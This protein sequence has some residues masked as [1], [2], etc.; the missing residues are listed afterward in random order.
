MNNATEQ[1]SSINVSMQGHVAIVEIRRPPNNYFDSALI[2]QIAAAFEA[3]E[4]AAAC[5]AIVLCSEGKVFCAGADLA[6]PDGIPVERS[7]REI[8]PIYQQALRLFACTKPVVCA[9]QGAAVGGGVGL[10]LV[11]DFRV[12]CSEARF[13]VNFNRLGFHPGFG[14]S[15]TLPRLIGLQAAAMLFYTGRR[16]GGEEALRIGLADELVPYEQVRSR[17]I[18]LATEIAIS[19]PLAVRSTRDT[20]RAGFLDQIRIAVARESAEQSW[21]FSTEDCKEG[22]KAMAERRTPVFNGS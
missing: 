18:E 16:I 3:L 20:L 5:R 12:T 17:A 4:A 13:S 19:S 11:A 9:V 22:I 6:Q 10:A 2:A 8:N 7:P 1:F 15:Y 14:L 21:Q